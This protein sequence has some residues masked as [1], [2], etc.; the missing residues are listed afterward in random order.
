MDD[1][2][3]KPVRKSA[4]ISKKVMRVVRVFQ[5]RKFLKY[6]PILRIEMKILMMS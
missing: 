6:L 2:M 3:P 5:R 1:N 4:N